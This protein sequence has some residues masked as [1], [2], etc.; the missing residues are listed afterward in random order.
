MIELQRGLGLRFEESAK[1]DARSALARAERTG[2]IRVE[3]GT[4]GGLA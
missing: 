3:H 1:I 2:Q 4:K